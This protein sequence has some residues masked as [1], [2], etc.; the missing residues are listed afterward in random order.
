MKVE[1]K[2]LESL[3][4]LDYLLELIIKN[5]I[6]WNFFS[7]RS[8]EFG[9]IV[10]MK[11]LLYRLKSYFSDQNLMKFPQKKTLGGIHEMTSLMC[12]IGIHLS[13]FF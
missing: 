7:L 13:S 11:I 2:K 4:I 5:L 9:S 3:Y 6:I 10:F 12:F 1:T 8:G